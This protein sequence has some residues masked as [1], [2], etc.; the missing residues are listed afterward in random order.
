[1][2]WLASSPCPLCGKGDWLQEACPSCQQQLNLP[3]TRLSG[4]S[5]LPWWG[6]GRF[7]GRLRTTL[8]RLRPEPDAATMQALVGGLVADLRRDR[9]QSW[10]QRVVLVPIP[11][12]QLN[13]NPLPGLLANCLAPGLG[14][15]QA[16]ELLQRSRP[17]LGQHRLQRRQRWANQQRS[18][19][20]VSPASAPAHGGAAVLLVDDVLT[21]GATGLAAAK[22]LEMAGWPVA[23]LICLARTPR[24]RH[25]KAAP[26]PR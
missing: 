8:L 26:R 4:R 24:Q 22:A 3:S 15:P 18:F 7:E 23:G 25:P 11:S 5:P 9:P 10:P 20:A 17:V 1:M 19:R 16:W 14:A 2:R 21:S 12:W 6:A 13:G